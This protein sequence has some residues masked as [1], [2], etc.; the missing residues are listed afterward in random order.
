MG[1][2]QVLPELLSKAKES[3]IQIRQYYF[4]RILSAMRRANASSMR[5]TSCEAVARATTLI[6][7]KCVSRIETLT[8][9][10][11]L[12]QLVIVGQQSA[13]KSSLLQSLTD[14]PFPVGDGLCTRF[15]TRIVS[16]RSPPGTPDLISVSIE[17]GETD[18]FGKEDDALTRSF[19]PSI[20]SLTAAAFKDVI[21]KVFQRCP[22]RNDSID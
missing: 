20:P 13:G 11:T 3:L 19:S 2:L 14:I 22:S 16:R 10:L 5:W 7:L 4:M 12:K 9:L 6:F 17:R 21:E 8:T 1:N 15:A 18:A